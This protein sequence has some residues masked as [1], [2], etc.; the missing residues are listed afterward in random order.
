[1]LLWIAMAALAAAACLPLLSPVNR[2][3]GGSSAGPSSSAA[4]M[5]IYRDQLAA[6]A[7]ETDDGL[8]GS[9]EAAGA[10]AEI[11][12]RLL[13]ESATPSER[14]V[15]SAR[16]RKI[17][18]AAIIAMPLAALAFYLVVGSP[19]TP[20]QPLASR[21][22]AMAMREVNDLV[23]R[24]EAHLATNPDD[25]KGWEVIAPVYAKLGRQADAAR[26]YAN[27]VRLLG[28]TAEREGDLGEAIFRQTGRVTDDARA[29]FERARAQAPQDVRPRFYLALGLTQ[30]ARTEEAKAAWHALLAD[31][32][33]NASWVPEVKRQLTLLDAAR[34]GPRQADVDAAAKLE[35]GRQQAMIEGMVTSLAERLKTSPDDTE[36]WVQLMRSYMVLGRAA[37]ARNALVDARLAVVDPMKRAAVDS[38]ARELGVPGAAP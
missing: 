35:P 26:A 32:P 13:R 23:A 9:G 24:V 10:R 2:Q 19:Q 25:G 3:R 20:D 22:D 11:A 18:S 31:A 8:V 36:G 33:A 28:S 27:V 14:V 38:A 6:L 17:A 16:A 34:T 15:P 12:R 37:D 7:R 29:A 1:M 30:D 21:P 4:A 5:A